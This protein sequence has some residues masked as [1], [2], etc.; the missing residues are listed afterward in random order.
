MALVTDHLNA[1]KPATPEPKQGKLTPAQLN[2]SKDLDADMK[3]EEPR[4]LAAFFFFSS[5]K[6]Q[7]QKA[8]K[9]PQATE[10]ASI[11]F[12]YFVVT[13]LRITH[14]QRQSSVHKPC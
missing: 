11:F 14:S 6:S 12:R 13:C 3:K 9:G 10:A 1:N 4:S 2:K 7:Q 5:T 8:K